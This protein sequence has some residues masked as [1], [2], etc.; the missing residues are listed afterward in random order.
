MAT[1]HT[2][3]IQLI[4][5]GF[6]TFSGFKCR[7]HPICLQVEGCQKMCGHNCLPAGMGN[8]LPCM[9][10]GSPTQDL[11]HH[12]PIYS[13]G[14]GFIMQTR[15]RCRWDSYNVAPQLWQLNLVLSFLI[16]R[17]GT[18]KTNITFVPNTGQDR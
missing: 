1:Y 8:I 18:K 13:Q 11:P 3:K 17:R 9:Q 14:P 15:S 2:H 7:R 10:N 12:N 6:L 4:R 16:Q 5:K